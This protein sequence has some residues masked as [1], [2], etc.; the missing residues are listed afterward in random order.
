MKHLQTILRAAPN[1]LV[2]GGPPCSSY[3]WVNRATS[4]RSKEK[5]EGM[6]RKNYIQMANLNLESNKS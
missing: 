4:G 3:V 2:F 1:A 6:T 5:P